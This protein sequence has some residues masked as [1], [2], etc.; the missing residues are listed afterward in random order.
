MWRLRRGPLGW[1]VAPG[2]SCH[3]RTGGPHRPSR[4]SSRPGLPYSGRVSRVFSPCSDPDPAWPWRVHLNGGVGLLRTP[5]RRFTEWDNTRVGALGSDVLVYWGLAPR[6][7]LRDTSSVDE[8]NAPALFLWTRRVLNTRTATSLNL[9]DEALQERRVER[10][11]E[12]NW[13]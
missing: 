13:T 10:Q 6:V 9:C 4:V 1:D 5:W 12:N 8:R 2:R 3:R 7:V 11:C